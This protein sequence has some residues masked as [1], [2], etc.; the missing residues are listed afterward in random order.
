MYN[1][2][3][4]HAEGH[5]SEIFLQTAGDRDCDRNRNR[6]EEE[7]EEESQGQ[8]TGKYDDRQ[9]NVIGTITRIPEITA[10]MKKKQLETTRFEE[11]RKTE[12]A[13][14]GGNERTN[15]DEKDKRRDCEKRS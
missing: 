5:V 13:M 11:A 15:R 7:E 3:W 6:K 9:K 12:R 14:E 2:S 4:I 1:I 8:T 10:D